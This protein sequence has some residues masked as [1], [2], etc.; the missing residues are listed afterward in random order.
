MTKQRKIVLFTWGS[1]GDILPYIS[2]AHELRELG[3]DAVIATAE[4]YRATVEAAGIRFCRMRPDISELTIQLNID[5][6]TLWQRYYAP[7]TGALFILRKLIYPNL[8]SS[9]ED[10]LQA[11]DGACLA[12]TSSIAYGAKVAAEK[13]GLPQLL[14]APMPLALMS[15]D[16]Q[17]LPIP[18]I[19]ERL[20]PRA[21]N[22]INRA[23]NQLI[24][25]LSRRIHLP[26]DNLRRQLRIAVPT[27]LQKSVFS[28]HGSLC[29]WSSCFGEKQSDFPPNSCITGF[30]YQNRLAHPPSLSAAL[31]QFLLNGEPPLIFTLGSF[32]TYS[33]KHF[34][35]ESIKA[36]LALGRRAII[37]TGYDRSVEAEIPQYS[38]IFVCDYAPHALLF[39]HAALIAHH[40]GIG[41]LAEAFRAAR[42]Q[43]IVPLSNDQPDNAHRAARLGVAKVL[44]LNQYRGKL[45]SAT[46]HHLLT[47]PTFK[48]KANHVAGCISLEN[49]ARTAAKFIRSCCERYSS[50][51]SGSP[52]GVLQ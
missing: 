3:Y 36:T 13:L 7:R 30:P 15:A 5:T 20:S 24:V 34:F 32:G 27:T 46:L 40:G 4:E 52:A 18:R 11:L 47:N 43:L 33:A 48:E 39:P 19:I 35:L 26:L 14:A 21:Y 17:S 37:L 28:E 51:V 6:Q 10:A 8:I 38:D 29:L 49:G 12:V 9:Y 25:D 2:I 41:T 1:L 42:P 45:L 31:Q 16:V 44:R 22:W 23:L 50:D